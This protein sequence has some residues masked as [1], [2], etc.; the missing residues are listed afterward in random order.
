MT[1][2]KSGLVN[3]SFSW[4]WHSSAPTCF[5]SFLQRSKDLKGKFHSLSNFCICISQ[6][7]E[8][9]TKETVLGTHWRYLGGIQGQEKWIAVEI[10]SSYYFHFL[11][12]NLATRCTLL[13]MNSISLNL[14]T[15]SSSL[16][17]TILIC[18]LEIM[19]F[20][21]LL[22]YHVR[23]MHFLQRFHMFRIFLHTK[24]QMKS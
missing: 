4:A 14:L 10:I 24:I 1:T 15:Y 8:T 12:K 23:L 11:T 13:W 20:Y 16:Y 9:L 22:L 7:L 17:L 2:G 21:C 3:P 18:S 19:L 6:Q 5:V